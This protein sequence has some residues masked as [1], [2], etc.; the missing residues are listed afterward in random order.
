MPGTPKPFTLPEIRD[1][2]SAQAKGHGQEAA[3][4]WSDGRVMEL[5]VREILPRLADGDRVLDVGCANGF[6][7]VQF[8]AQRPIAIRGVD[9]IPEMI[10]SA[11]ERLA[12]LTEALPG[13]VEF[14]QGDITELR[15]PSGVYDKIVCIRVLINLGDWERQQRGLAECARVL[16]PGGTLLLSE[17]TLQGWQRLN[18]FRRE[19]GLPD[20]PMPPFN[21]YLDEEK[22]AGELPG[23]LKVAEIVNFAS[24][25]YVGTRVLKPLLAKALGGAIDPADPHMEWNRWFSQMPAWGDYGTQKLFVLKKL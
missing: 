16:K 25:Y 4:S 22:F 3:A 23:G 11:R 20:I 10:D 13:T 21:H 12:A 1:F 8:A 6:S 2:W 19:W 24:S 17:A 5:E 14:D 18:Q 9:Y 7:T 15:E